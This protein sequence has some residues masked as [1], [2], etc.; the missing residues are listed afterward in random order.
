MAQEDEK[1]KEIAGNVVEALAGIEESFRRAKLELLKKENDLFKPLYAKREK[2]TAAIPRFWSTVLSIEDELLPYIKDRESDLLKSCTSLKIDRLDDPRDFCLSLSFSRNSYLENSSLNMTKQFKFDGGRLTSKPIKL[3]W[4]EGKNLIELAERE[5]RLSFFSILTF[6]GTDED[7][8]PD[9]MNGKS[10]ETENDNDDDED[11][12]EEEK[13][14]PQL[15]LEDM[16]M[17]LADEVYPHALSYFTD[18]LAPPDT[19]AATPPLLPTT[20]SVNDSGASTPLES[21]SHSFLDAQAVAVD[22]RA[23]H[24]GRGKNFQLV[25]N[26][27]AVEGYADTVSLTFPDWLL[28]HRSES[29]AAFNEIKMVT[30]NEAQFLYFLARMQKTER[31]LEIGCFTGFSALVFALAGANEVQTC[32]CDAALASFA[33]LAIH[34]AGLSSVV[35]VLTGD[36]HSTLRDSQ[37]VRG[38]YDL[39]FIDAEKEG[40]TAYLKLIL[41]RNLLAPTGVIV[42]DNTLR[43]GCVA[44]DLPVRHKVTESREAARTNDDFEQGVNAIKDFNTFVA[45]LDNLE[46]VLVPCWDGVTLIR[47]KSI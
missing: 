41:S 8:Q 22:S 7:T 40:Y 19:P 9:R 12:E 31:V 35:S 2:L 3:D 26:A 44:I 29:I 42:A 24:I 43:R 47:Y 23:T 10:F 18:A 4:K 34:K 6:V 1:I 45:G 46:S 25:E 36:A 28:Q 11:E 32:E 15:V 27:A 14:D 21:M 20:A 30:T 5:G 13:E 39:I 37:R 33:K 17:L 38:P 16:A